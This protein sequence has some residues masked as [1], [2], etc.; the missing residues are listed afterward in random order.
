MKEDTGYTNVELWLVDLSKFSSVIE[1]SERFDKDGGRLDILVMN[2]AVLM[3]VYEAT[4]DHWESTFVSY[5]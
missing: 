4:E 1:F 2:A 5:H 3:R